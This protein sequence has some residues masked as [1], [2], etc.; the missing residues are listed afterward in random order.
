MDLAF[1]HEPVEENGGV[2]E[3][4]LA[5]N[6]DVYS[7]NTAQAWLSALAA[8]ARWLAEDI[9]RADA[10]LPALLPEES[11]CLARWEHGP[12]RP[13]PAKRFHELFEN[14]ADS[15]PDR[16][17]VVTETEVR[18]YA[19]LDDQANRIA[20]ALLEHGVVCEEPVAVLTE[21]SAD[22][23]ATVL[24]IW[25]A[26]ASYLPLALEQPP[27][28]LAYMA[29]DAGARTLIVLDGHAVPPALAKVVTTILGPEAWDGALGAERPEMA[30]TPQDLA[31][32]I[33]TSGTTGMPKGALIQHD[34]LVNAAYASGEIF[35]LTPD[36]RF[37]LVATPGFDASLWELGAALLH[38]MAIV[39]ISRTLRDDPW[40]LK[41]WYKTYGVT[42]AFHAPSYLRV[43]QQTPFE[44]L[45][46]LITGGEAPNHDDARHHANLALWNAYGP[47]ETCI[48]TC[49]E[50]LSPHPDASR[51]LPLGRP[52][53][54]TSISIRR[55]NGDPVPLGVVGE[56]WLSG[57]GLARGYLNNPDLTARQ[58]VETPEGRFYR[59]GD[60]G[61]WTEDGRLELAGRIDHQIKLHGQRVE[62]G[63]IEQALRSHPAVEE[64]VTLVEASANDTKVLRSFVRLHAVAAMPTEREWRSYLGDHL[65]T[66][67]VPASVVSVA[68][69]PLTFAGKIDRDALLASPRMRTDGVLKSPPRGEMETRIAAVWAALLGD[70][71]SR[72]DNFFALGGNSLLAITMAHRLSRE[73]ARPIPARELF[74]APTLASFAQRI[75]D[76]PRTQPVVPVKSDLATEGQREFRVAEAAGLDTRSFAMPLLRKIEGEMPS[77]GRWNAAW[78]SLVSRHD[79]LR[80]GFPEDADGR[81]RRATTVVTE[82]RP[83][84]S[85]GS[86]D[87]VTLPNMPAA[88]AFFRNRQSEPFVMAAPPLWR[89]GLIEVLD[90]GEHLFWLVL[91]HSVGDGRSLGIL[92]QELAALLRGEELP[93]LAYDFAESAAA[94]EA[95]LAGPP[96]THDARYWR[97]LL[98]RQPDSAFDEGPLDF[99]RSLTGKTGMHRFEASLDSSTSQ[100]LKTLAREHEA[101]LHAVMVT[102]LALEARRRAPRTDV[103]IGTTASVR[104]T[105]AEEQVVGYYVNMLP[106]P[107]HLPRDLTF[108]AAL[109]QTQQ[110]LAEGLQHARYPFARIYHDFW[111]D[112]PHLRHPARYPLFD[113]A[114]TESPGSRPETASPRLSRLPALAYELTDASP[115]QDMI[116]IHEDQPDGSLLLQWQVNATLFNRETASCWFEALNG[117]AVWL[118]EDRGRARE[119]LPGLLPRETALL[120]A[121]EQGARI[122]RPTLRFHELFERVH[123]L[124]GQC[125]R[126]A[127]ITETSTTTYGALEQE[128]N[129]I[130]HGLL[131]RG[132][133][134]GTAVGVLTGR[135]ANLPAAVLGIWKA[136]ATYLP[137]AAD[138][139]PERLA[140][141]ARDAHATLL[142]ALDGFV[143]QALLPAVSRLI[144]TLRPEDLDAEFRRTHAHRP[145]PSPASSDAAYITYTSGS[146]GRPKG[147]LIGHESF[148]N[149]VLGTGETIGLT[150]T[151]RSLMF[152]SPSF[153]VSLSDIGLPLAFGA[154]LCPVPYEVLSSPNRFRAFLTKL[155]RDRGRHHAHLSAA[156]RWSGA[157]FI[158]HPDHRRRGAVSGGCRDLCQPPPLLQRLWSHRKHHHQHDGQAVV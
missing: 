108:G 149:L 135:S 6:P 118:A 29:A 26:G 114:V 128:A 141:M 150:R 63:D 68:S 88:H 30:G 5:W 55:D 14:L 54:N 115:G 17:A 121:W 62:L 119:A 140:F 126:A 125:D 129:A 101:S 145:P 154:A 137:L 2:L 43:S 104:E 31:Y 81:L 7:R 139:P 72:E 124:P 92:V 138:L 146:T 76:L 96:C 91:H 97:D 74:A 56:V 127:I 49:A 142:I 80:T 157:A 23:P 75:A 47:T 147:T 73:L 33:Y 9:S 21:C 102:L 120:E 83:S 52:M 3:L 156:F 132:A 50:Q 148:V 45:R 103:V 4:T 136:G 105:A 20:R 77:L 13:R 64:A 85:G 155:E 78:A 36:D 158:A 34:S 71:I 131:L 95:Y 67:M 25:K 48:F 130:A 11:Q 109:R 106:V 110:A 100:G 57:T 51:P 32:I 38:G 111:S 40:A 116:L 123:D 82:Q 16:A 58:F 69:I 143:A 18:T 84:G 99:P 65:P 87:T 8:W 61:R 10:P 93:P 79:S 98:A 1:S 53:P 89:A 134:P 44:G 24:G 22:L 90:S 70:G 117:W 35:G 133:A 15:H 66:Y 153:D 94:E 151:D 42:I 144:S 86:L 60:L 122:A 46:I 27:D 37:S 112:R 152:A 12:A 59:S 41:Q 113:L 19:D 28:R 39:P 107:C